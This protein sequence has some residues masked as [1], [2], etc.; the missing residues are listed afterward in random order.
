MHMREKISGKRVLVLGLGR[1]GR[2]A[3][4]LLLHAGAAAVVIN[5]SKEAAFLQKEIADLSAFPNVYIE[6]G[7]HRD[8]LLQD[9]S[10]IIK[11]PG[12]NP[13]LTLLQEAALRGLEIISEVELA[14]HFCP[15]PLA[16]ITGTNGK[17]TTT[18]LAGEMFRLHFPYV[19]VAGNIGYPLSEAVLHAAGGD[20]I[21]AEL[22]SFQLADIRDFHAHIAAILNISADHLDYH[23]SM[24]HY[25]EAKCNI[26]RRQQP[27]D[28]SV[29]NWDDP[30][31]RGLAR[32]VRGTL[33]P[34]SRQE[35]I[36][37]G[38]YVRNGY[39][40]VNDGKDDSAICAVADV[41]IPGEHNL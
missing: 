24:A 5:D 33:L 11:S 12:L 31:T 7:G 4:R 16:A 40:M 6:A 1:S 10:F 30:L 41:R 8:E 25:I 34:F 26:L 39:I 37:P 9:I 32:F 13:R 15:V 18:A 17:T 14:Y 19:Q 23:G 21:V 36:S 2:A 29:F 38:I 20:Y 22:S 28:W 27:G 35:K 3:A